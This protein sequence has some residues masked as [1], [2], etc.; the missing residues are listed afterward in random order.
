MEIGMVSIIYSGQYYS[1][2]L[3]D[4]WV[5]CGS[6]SDA[7]TD[8]DLIWAEYS[9][10][11]LFFS[12]T[13]KK[14]LICKFLQSGSLYVH[15]LLSY[16]SRDLMTVTT[17]EACNYESLYVSQLLSTPNMTEYSH[18]HNP[19]RSHATSTYLSPVSPSKKLMCGLHIAMNF[20]IS[21]IL[22]YQMI[23]QLILVP[24]VTSPYL[25]LMY[26]D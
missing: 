8:F 6:N 17:P 21:M 12:N 2:T 23:S 19:R 5:S 24:H 11:L 15:A 16:L 7:K 3:L 9:V 25:H 20:S 18:L 14:D 10:I 13:M 22:Q 26:V 4:F 1:I